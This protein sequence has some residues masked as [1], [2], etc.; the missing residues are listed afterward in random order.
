M[1]CFS[2]R[3]PG[4]PKAKRRRFQLR[5]H[6]L[7]DLPW[8]QAKL[9]LDCIECRAIFPCHLDDSIFFSRTQAHDGSFC[10]RVEAG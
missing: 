1:L 2:P 7:D 9:R 10:F 8:R 5:S 4:P 6:E 3:R